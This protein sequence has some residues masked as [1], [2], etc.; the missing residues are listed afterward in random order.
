MKK[1]YTAEIAFY[2]DW[3]YTCNHYLMSN[4]APPEFRAQLISSVE[5]IKL[6]QIP[7]TQAGLLGAKEAYYDILHEVN[8]I[9]KDKLL[10]LNDALFKSM[11]EI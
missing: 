3:C 2:K 1:D 8:K 4:F 6:I 10:E 11:E 9:P 5:Q 7:N